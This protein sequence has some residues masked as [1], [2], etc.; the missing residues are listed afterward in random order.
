MAAWVWLQAHSQV[1]FIWRT[2]TA[3]RLHYEPSSASVLRSASGWD[4][5][6]LM[7]KHVLR[8][9]GIEHACSSERILNKTSRTPGCAPCSVPQYIQKGPAQKLQTNNSFSLKLRLLKI[10]T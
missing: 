2:V 10:F 1:A 9:G 4:G 3:L 6:V 8:I 7:Q 5:E